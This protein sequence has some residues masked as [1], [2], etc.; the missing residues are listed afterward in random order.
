MP[1]DSVEKKNRQNLK[2]LADRLKRIGIGVRP[3]TVVEVTMDAARH[4]LEKGDYR[5]GVTSEEG[6]TSK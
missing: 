2:K 4:S 5:L 3:Q 1:M 6:K